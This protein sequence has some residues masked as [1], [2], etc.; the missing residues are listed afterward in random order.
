MQA[1]RDVFTPHPSHHRLSAPIHEA[2]PAPAELD[3]LIRLLDDE[4]PEVRSRVAQRIAQCGGDLSEWL[5]ANPRSL[6]SRERVLLAELLQPA[7]RATLERDW[8]MPTG[9]AAALRDDWDGFE[10]LLR[11]ISDF[12]HDGVSIRQPLSDAL[13]LLAEE[14]A[15][16][17]VASANELRVFLFADGRLV[18][19]EENYDDP[20]NSD[21]AW[22]IAEGR[23]NPLGLAVIFLLVARRLEMV[24]EAV[25]FPGHFLA[26]IY[27]DGYPLIIDC[28]DSGR[29][30][31][32]ATL[33]ENPEMG[34]Q[35][36]E[37]L[38][39]SADPGTILRRLLNNLGSALQAAGRKEDAQLA[40]KLRATLQ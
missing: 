37:I 24:V 17:G 4:T 34:R 11:V 8:Q 25:N 23:S 6:S 33:L 18:G 39:Q 13:D 36:R 19:N 10:A 12:L 30:H 27:E 20:R 3:A 32:Q 22:S 14:A 35:E 5:A 7:R 40:H 21:L 2:A 28:F 1:A 15:Q 29:P 16:A 26:R 9:G 31:L 38:R